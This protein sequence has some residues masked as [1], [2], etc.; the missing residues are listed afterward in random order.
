MSPGSARL[1]IHIGLNYPLDSV[2]AGNDPKNRRSQPQPGAPHLAI[3]EMWVSGAARPRSEHIHYANG[4]ASTRRLGRDRL[5]SMPMRPG[6][7][8]VQQEGEEHP[9]KTQN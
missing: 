6:F 3:F 7:P 9:Q 5:Q 1:P 2:V 4:R 8:F